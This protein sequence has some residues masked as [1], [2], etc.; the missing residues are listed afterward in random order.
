MNMK[1]SY[2][3]RV[4]SG[5]ESRYIYTASARSSFIWK[6]HCLLF[7]YNCLEIIMRPSRNQRFGTSD[8]QAQLWDERLHQLWDQIVDNQA[9]WVSEQLGRSHPLSASRTRTLKQLRGK[10]HRHHRNH[11]V[12]VPNPAEHPPSSSACA[13]RPCPPSRRPLA[14]TS[15]CRLLHCHRLHCQKAPWDNYTT[16]VPKSPSADDEPGASR[17]CPCS[18]SQL[19]WVIWGARIRGID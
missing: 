2:W 9:Q 7:I 19:S 13:S 6:R 15:R 1:A 3:Q 4:R 5:P 10:E 14:S 11:A 8:H 16:N 17:A 12:P 18:W